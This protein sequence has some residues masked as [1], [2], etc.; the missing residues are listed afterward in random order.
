MALTKMGRDLMEVAV[1]LVVQDSKA[2]CNNIEAQVC[3][4]LGGW[5]EII[6]VEGPIEQNWGA[7][8][9]CFGITPQ[10][11]L[12]SSALRELLLYLFG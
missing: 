3:L 11:H 8:I 7:I 12:F 5:M 10:R 6:T 1:N 2:G 9:T 4:C